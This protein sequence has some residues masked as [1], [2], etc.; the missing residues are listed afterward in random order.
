MD[1]RAARLAH[2]AALGAVVERYGL[3]DPVGK[4]TVRR[5]YAD[6]YAL[7]K[8]LPLE[9]ALEHIGKIAAMELGRW[10]SQPRT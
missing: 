5:I 4:A 6:E 9:A 2:A 3:T 10:H 8:E 7:V 1:T